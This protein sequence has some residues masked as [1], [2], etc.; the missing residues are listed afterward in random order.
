[1]VRAPRT[2]FSPT[3]GPIIASRTRS[4]SLVQARP[5]RALN[6]RGSIV[7]RARR[8]IVHRDVDRLHGLLAVHPA[9]RAAQG[10][11]HR[12][13]GK[14]QQFGA[15]GPEHSAGVLEQG[16]DRGVELRGVVEQPAGFVQEL[17]PLVLL[18][19]AHVGA[20]CGEHDRRRH[21]QEDSERGSTHRTITARI[22]R[23]LLAIATIS[24]KLSIWG[25]FRNWGA[26]PGERD[27]RGDEQRLDG[28]RGATDE[29]GGEPFARSG[30]CRVR[31]DRVEDA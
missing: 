18:A 16:A 6:A 2:P 24:L 3:S 15:L 22:A 5:G 13:V 21:G 11:I 31:R 23:L 10:G 14:E 29:E 4:A 26:P 19:F 30:W 17:E 7:V 9:R 28:A 20:V 1:M 27:G 12:R 8:R 25:S